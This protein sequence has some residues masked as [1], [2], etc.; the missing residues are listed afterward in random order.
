MVPSMALILAFVFALLLIVIAPFLGRELRSPT[1]DRHQVRI[2]LFIQVAAAVAVV[3][4]RVHLS[5]SASGSGR[6]P[7]MSG[8]NAAVA[9]LGLLSFFTALSA[10]FAAGRFK[11]STDDAWGAAA[12]AAGMFVVSSW[13][14]V[15]AAICD[16]T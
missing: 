3:V 7:D 16:P 8:Q 2:A 12:L 14:I 5:H 6:C 4:W 11:Q 13:I 10:A 15:T 9:G 1:D